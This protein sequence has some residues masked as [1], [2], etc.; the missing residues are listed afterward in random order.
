[1]MW[2]TKPLPSLSVLQ[3]VSLCLL[4]FLVSACPQVFA[5]ET[6]STTSTQAGQEET[7]FR[8]RGKPLEPSERVI[9]PIEDQAPPYLQPPFGPETKSFLVRS[10]HVG[11]SVLIPE[12]EA[13]RLVAS[14]EG[15]ALTLADLRRLAQ[16]LT[17]WLRGHAYVTSRVYVPPQEITD[18]IVNIQI[19]E[20]RIGEIRVEG[21][22]YSRPD[23]LTSRMDT[24]PGAFF[25]YTVLQQDLARLAA[26][27][28]RRVMAVLVAGKTP[29]TTDIVVKVE[30]HLPVHLGYFLHNSGTKLTGRFRQGLSAGYTNLTGHDDQFVFRTEFSNRS[31]FFGVTANYLLPLAGS[32]GT[33]GFDVSHANVELGR[34]FRQNHVIG[35]ATVLGLNW[36]K[37]IWQTEHWETEWVTGFDWKRVRSR[38]IGIDR[39]KDDLRVLKIGPNILEQDA[40]GRS[41]VTNEVGIGFSEFLGG[42]HKID[43][44]ASRASTGG[45]FTRVDFSGGRLQNLVGGWQL[46]ARGTVQLTDRR[47]P[48]SEAIR[49]GG[50][51]SVRGYPEGEILGD[52]GYSG[53]AELR[54]PISVPSL[55][56][57]EKS[58][59]TVV[60]FVDGGAAFLRKP[61]LGE[62]EKERLVGVGFGARWA[63]NASTNL[64][65]D[66]GWPVGND[67]SEGNA[68]RLYYALNIGF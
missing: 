28:D 16:E 26:N 63:L 67:A 60:G 6:S 17:Q 5:A 59:L 51:E 13:K 23:A 50:E 53:T 41:I 20:G 8:R 46:L 37:P 65:L 29:G 40:T 35:N 32:W 54:F 62:E 18:G 38:E 10:I 25:R 27:P 66:V 45:Q 68:P 30:E 11:G 24:K 31:D 7:Q 57:M 21:A 48:P 15:R 43:S 9:P 61:I 44:A 33:L 22:K 49:L 4:V 12:D 58:K 1:M 34:Q 55:G 52:Y 3:T 19:L 64:L 47:L 36:A 42:S 14:Y 56:K 2:R 39:G